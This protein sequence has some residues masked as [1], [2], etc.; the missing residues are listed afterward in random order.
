ML[1]CLAVFYRKSTKMGC[2]SSQPFAAGRS[3]VTKLDVSLCACWPA[4][5]V[6]YKNG[7]SNVH[8]GPVEC[9]GAVCKA[10][11]RGTKLGGSVVCPPCCQ[12]R[13]RATFLTA[14]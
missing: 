9:P 13:E 10:R 3:A 1:D 5:L 6:D 4:W 2:L 12:Q 11:V 7:H 14:S 8:V